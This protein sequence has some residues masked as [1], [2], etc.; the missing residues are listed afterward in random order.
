M[1][2]P[3]PASATHGRYARQPLK[4]RKTLPTWA[5][6]LTVLAVVSIPACGVLGSIMLPAY[7]D[8]AERANAGAAL[9]GAGAALMRTVAEYHAARG[10]CPGM[11]DP[12]VAQVARRLS[13]HSQALARVHFGRLAGGY[14]MFELT[15][16][17][18]RAEAD[19]KTLRYVGWKEGGDFAWDC[20]EGS[21]PDAW[22]PPQCQAG[23]AL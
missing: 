14:C 4:T 19:G 20:S 7:Q 18:D 3:A 10:T 15:L 8:Y 9:A 22:R 17:H 1:P 16:R 6:V 11:D 2:A 12:R 21:L 5:I 23:D 13:G